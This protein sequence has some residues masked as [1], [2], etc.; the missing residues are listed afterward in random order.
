MIYYIFRHGETYYSK[1]D[2]LYEDNNMTAEILPESIPV[3][4]RMANYLLDKI[5]D[6]NYTSPFIRAVQTVDI[7]TKITKKKFLPDE[8]LKEEGLSRAEETFRQL[9]GRLKNFINEIEGKKFNNV[10][11]CSHGWPIAT[12]LAI[13]IKG[14]VNRT[15]LGN[16]PKCGQLLIVENRSLKT[17][18]FN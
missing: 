13:L 9:E 12:M 14:K 10:A 16:F 18:D 17:L 11:I 5:D 6:Q 4:E 2:V 7:I 8:R 1:N 15:D 3:S